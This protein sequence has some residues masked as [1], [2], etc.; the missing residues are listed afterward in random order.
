LNRAIL[1]MVVLLLPALV[2]L[3]F[4]QMSSAAGEKI[5]VRHTVIAASGGAAPAGGNYLLFLNAALN[6]R[7]EV[8]F[9]AFIGGPPFTTGVFV[10]DGKTTSTIALGVNPDPAAP[11]FGS[12]F[13][14]FITS[15]GDVVFDVN[16]GDIFTSHARTIVPLV[17]D[18]DPAPGG[19][20]V[21]PLVGTRAVNDHGAV[22]YVASLSGSTA[23]QG[24]FRT[25][26]TQTVTIARDDNGPPTGGSFTLFSNTVMNDRGQVAFFSEMTGGSAD[27]GIFRGEGGDLTPVFV[28][29][30]IAPGGAVFKDFGNPVINRH[31]QVA[32]FASLRNSASSQGLFVGDG[33]DAVAIALEGQSAPKGGSYRDA[34]GRDAFVGPIRLNDRGEVAFDAHLTGGTSS[35][36]I[37][38]GIGERTTTVALAGTT[39][40]GTT[41]TFESFD[42]FKLGIDGRVAFIGTLALGVGGVDLSNNKG[43]WIG[44]S[45]EDLKLVVRTGD[46]IDGKVLTRLPQFGQS[47]NQFD[48][49]ENGVLWVGSFG[50][51]K[52]VVFSRILAEN[53]GLGEDDDVDI[54]LQ[55]KNGTGQSLRVYGRSYVPPADDKV[56]WENTSSC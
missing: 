37:F 1:Y 3:P 27:F 55:F 38:R 49:N 26:G 33:T 36:G 43:I 35:S 50:L 56:R 18:G 23:T 29:N 16:D 19:G 21:T 6:A 13:N 53:D 39:A 14:P 24:I 45:D 17:R 9:D 54:P 20:T 51:A 34:L 42:D 10:G 52:V 5:A 8:A 44:T 32:T 22:A 4:A 15:N 31:G 40:P 47:G 12:V 30:Q 2:A 25:D 48:M 11:S 41:G 7:H 28:A 46:V